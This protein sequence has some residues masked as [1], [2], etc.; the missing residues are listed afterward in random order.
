[1]HKR[2]NAIAAVAAATGEVLADRTIRVCDAEFDAALEW[3]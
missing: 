3:A 2:S 1:M